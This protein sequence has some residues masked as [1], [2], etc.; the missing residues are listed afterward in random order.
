AEDRR[1]ATKFGY[2][3]VH[4]VVI[5]RPIETTRFILVRHPEQEA[6]TFGMEVE[7]GRKIDCHR[8]RLWNRGEWFSYETHTPVR[9]HLDLDTGEFAD[10]SSVRT[11]RDHD[12]RRRDGA[13][14]RF[15]AADMAVLAEDA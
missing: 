9:R 14:R 10:L 15:H 5:D 4:P 12:G 13:G 2:R 6:A 11:G 7:S 8:H 1:S 3:A